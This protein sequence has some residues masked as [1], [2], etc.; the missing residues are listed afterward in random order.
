MNED[1]IIKQEYVDKSFAKGLNFFKLFW[2]FFIGCFAGVIVET[3]WCVY[4]NGVLESRT[5]LVFS[6]LNP[7]YGFGA[8][9]ITLCF[10]RVSIKKKATIFFGCMFIGGVFEYLCSLFQEMAF[11]TVSWSYSSDVLGIFERTS[12]LYCVFWGVLGLLWVGYIYPKLSNLIER[13]PNKVGVNLTYFLVAMITID[14]AV[15]SY[16]VYR[17]SERRQGV[18]AR[19][20]IHE[21]FDTRF[22][23]DV[24]KAIYPNMTPVR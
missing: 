24:L 20:E 12:L 3:I 17:Q 10:V 2:I 21:F 23:D 13:I 4:K 1:D 9:L 18:P 16:A 11:G 6:P 22:N 7:V 8:V 19:N 14:M 15:S 5:A